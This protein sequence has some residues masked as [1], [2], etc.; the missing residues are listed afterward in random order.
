MLSSPHLDCRRRLEPRSP[1]LF[2]GLLLLITLAAACG[3]GPGTG[4]LDRLRP[5][6]SADGP[7]D[8][9]CGSFTVFEDRAAKSGRQIALWI[10]VLPAV[11]PVTGDPV[12]FLAGGPG[13]GAAKLARQIR[14]A[15]RTVQ[16]TRDI[17]LVDQRGTGKSNPLNCRSDANSLRE[18]TEPTESGIE[19]LKRCLA[20]YNADVRL[21]TTNIAM[22]DLDDV[23]AYLGYDRIN[24]YGGSYGT[25]AALVYLRRH[26]ERVR[27]MILDGVAPMDMRLPMFTARD[28]QRALD[29]LLADCEADAACQ[30][31]FPE[32]AARIR[33]LLMRL[34]QS[35]PTVR[36][37]HPRTGTAEEIRVEARVVASILFSALYSPLTASIVPALVDQA[38]RNEFQGIFALGL[39]GEGTDENM[40][41][42]MQLSVLCSEDAARVTPTDVEQAA[43]GTLF[44]LH[45][46]SSQLKACEM[47]PRG[48]VEASYYEP[49]VSDVPA[50][51]LSGDLD[52]VT[53]PTWGEAV[54]KSLK[55]GRHITAPGT[56]HGVI[57]T[58][59][60]QRLIQDF[61][62]SAASA[63]LDASCVRSIKRPPFFVTPA[64]PDPVHAINPGS[65]PGQVWGRSGAGLGQVWGRS[66]PGLGQVWGRSGPGLGQ[67]P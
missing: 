66:G 60:G 43:A 5:C 45:L 53:P 28:A 10:V 31:A 63:S 9:Y 2:P 15:F 23:R 22:D 35:P 65:G 56:G 57:A 19:R 16:R 32:L 17:V 46:L 41:V 42:G 11:R 62:D 64:G 12:V 27:T 50:L 36:I 30:R 67:A 4:A 59:C 34:E 47:W 3:G 6:T 58:A 54:V 38:E 14:G 44:G 61:L 8:A 39:A 52:P 13:Q 26:G 33:T 7:T 40:S 55:N 21:Y 25:R 24:L 1:R 37:V 29:K 48:V 18:L 49:V 20:S 51:V